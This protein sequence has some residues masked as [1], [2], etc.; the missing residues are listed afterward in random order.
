MK[1]FTINSPRAVARTPHDGTGALF[2]HHNGNSGPEIASPGS[3][4]CPE[5][6]PKTVP[7]GAGR[8]IFTQDIAYEP[9]NAYLCMLNLCS[10]T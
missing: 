9:N 4:F 8:K 3:R 7:R 6:P 2:H 5:A 10:K 1:F